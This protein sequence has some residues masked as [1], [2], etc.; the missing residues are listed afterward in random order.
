LLAT[1][2]WAGVMAT[3]GGLVFGGSNE[4]NLYAVDATSGKPLWQFQ[5]G[6]AIR[7]APMSF[8]AEG[9]QR[10]AVAGGRSVFVFG[11]E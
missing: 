1:P 6:G 4:G 11:I 7:C 10:I 2:P 9:K 8:L 3:A 5:T